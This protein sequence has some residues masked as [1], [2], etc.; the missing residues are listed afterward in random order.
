MALNYVLSHQNSLLFRSRMFLITS[1]PTFYLMIASLLVTTILCIDLI[2]LHVRPMPFWVWVGPVLSVVIPLVFYYV[3][4]RK[5]G[6]PSQGNRKAMF[7]FTMSHLAMALFM[8]LFSVAWTYYSYSLRFE[9]LYM[10]S[11]QVT[12]LLCG[13]WGILALFCMMMYVFVIRDEEKPSE[14]S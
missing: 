5:Y 4:C 2:D 7:M 11:S 10:L 8:G 9:D 12:F 13:L 14:S 1:V 6:D 3:A